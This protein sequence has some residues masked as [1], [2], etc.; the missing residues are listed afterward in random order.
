[1]NFNKHFDEYEN[2]SS[3][4]KKVAKNLVNYMSKKDVFKEEN[5]TI[6]EIGCGTGIFTREY[7]KEITGKNNLILND[8]FDVRKYI[9]D[10]EYKIFK[11]GDVL[12]ITIDKSD[13]ILSSSVFQWVSDLDRL[14]KKISESSKKL[15]FSTYIAGNLI[16]IKEHFG[17]SLNY[18]SLEEIEEVAKLYF[19]ERSF[20]KETIKINFESPLELLRHLKYTGVTGLQRP[21]VT[22]IRSFKNKTLSYEV[23]YF[24]CKN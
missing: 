19:K 2:Y 15:C 11:E 24:I 10:I 4:Q 14:L 3:V 23:A 9:A 21:S 1:M 13:L 17:L 12:N 6:F 5:N 20:Y 7:R 22:N 16:E 18:R 8:K